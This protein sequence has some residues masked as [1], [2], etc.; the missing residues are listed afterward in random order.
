MAVIARP[1]AARDFNNILTKAVSFN[2]FVGCFDDTGG[3][4]VWVCM[5]MEV[6]C[7]DRE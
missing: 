6:F 4:F 3:R 1:A 5:V 2:V 7:F